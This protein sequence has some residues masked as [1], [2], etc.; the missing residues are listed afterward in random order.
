MSIIKKPQLQERSLYF[1]MTAQM[2]HMLRTRVLLYHICENMSHSVVNRAHSSSRRR[3]GGLSCR[4]SR[5]SCHC[6]TIATVHINLISPSKYGSTVMGFFYAHG[7]GATV[8]KKTDIRISLVSR[9]F[10][11]ELRLSLFIQQ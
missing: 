3:T 9:Q 1:I 7:T 10:S 2:D 4:F 11:K 5:F 8:G 6:V